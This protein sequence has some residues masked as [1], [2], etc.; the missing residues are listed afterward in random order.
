VERLGARIDTMMSLIGPDHPALW[1][2]TRTLLDRGPYQNAHTQSW[3]KA[4]TQAC[5][6]HPNM[7]VYDWASEVKDEW[8]S[9]DGIHP[10]GAGYRE[11]A[12][13]IPRAL[14][15]AFP[16]DGAPPAG[17]LVGSD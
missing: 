13:R 14:A 7:R 3:T 6:R 4:L 5:A 2:T 10:G 12:A 9:K 1:T 15:R 11:R 17:C 8:I 16:K